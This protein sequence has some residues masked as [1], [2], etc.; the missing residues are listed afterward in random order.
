MTTEL[1]KIL[2]VEDDPSIAAVVT[3]TLEMLG[4]YEVKHCLSGP[5]AI[6]AAPEYAPQ[7]ILMDMMMPGM[8]GLE[9]LENLKKISQVANTPVIFMTAKAQVQEQKTYEKAGAI[10]VIIKPF[11]TKELCPR[12]EELWEDAK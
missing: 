6:D 5:E 8:D 9:T 2:Y 3:M 12:I 4:D 10:G 1:K 7:L 11:D